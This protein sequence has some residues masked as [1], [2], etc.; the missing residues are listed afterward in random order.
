MK[1][2]YF[3]LSGTSESTEERQTPP[4]KDTITSD[5]VLKKYV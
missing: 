2:M 5:V 1:W 4:N 3:N